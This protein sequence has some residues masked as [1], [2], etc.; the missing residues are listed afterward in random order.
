MGSNGRIEL[1]QKFVSI[2]CGADESRK[3][4]KTIFAIWG[5]WRV[6]QNAKL[7]RKQIN[8]AIRSQR[9][10]IWV[11]L[12]GLGTFLGKPLHFDLSHS[13]ELLNTKYGPYPTTVDLQT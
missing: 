10:L 13:P 9:E 8:R 5:P 12:A 11:T 3:L 4:Y 7:H 6:R 1:Q 2:W